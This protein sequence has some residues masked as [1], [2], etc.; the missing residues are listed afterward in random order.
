[1][2]NN[3]FKEHSSQLMSDTF[4]LG[5]TVI[6]FSPEQLRKRRFYCYFIESGGTWI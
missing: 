6:Y 2:V 5:S 1:M 3:A 4:L